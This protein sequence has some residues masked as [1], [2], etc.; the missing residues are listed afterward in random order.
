MYFKGTDVLQNKK[1]ENSKA[2]DFFLIGREKNI[3]EINFFEIT[4][5]KDL[6]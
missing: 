1:D 5:K 2:T 4:I 6:K 3:I